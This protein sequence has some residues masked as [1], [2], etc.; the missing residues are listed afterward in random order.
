MT[1]EPCEFCGEA[2]GWYHHD[3]HMLCDGCV[4]RWDQQQGIEP[5]LKE[6]ETGRHG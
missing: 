4:T 2:P 6:P 3:D 1:G 5:I